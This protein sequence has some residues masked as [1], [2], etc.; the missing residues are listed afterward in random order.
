[1]CWTLSAGRTGSEGNSRPGG[2][3]VRERLL[4]AVGTGDRAV[5]YLK[6]VQTHRLDDRPMIACPA[7]TM[8]A[9]LPRWMIGWTLL[10]SPIVPHQTAYPGARARD[11]AGLSH[12]C[13]TA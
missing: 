3:R 5:G 11:F 13:C 7:T 9:T 1:M 10:I 2:A 6:R 12:T 4:V 8:A